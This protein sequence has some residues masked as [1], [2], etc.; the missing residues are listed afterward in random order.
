MYSF[1]FKGNLELFSKIRV[2]L[3]KFGSAVSATGDLFKPDRP[4]LYCVYKF[5]VRLEYSVLTKFPL[6]G[7]AKYEELFM[8][9]SDGH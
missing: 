7:F 5:S 9:T 4:S 1:F 3:W 8:V 6:W 2:F